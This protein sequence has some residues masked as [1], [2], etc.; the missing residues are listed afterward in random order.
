MK[1][2]DTLDHDILFT[3]LNNFGIGKGILDWCKDYLSSRFQSVKLGGEKSSLFPVTCGVPQG[4]LLGSLYFII[5][6][7]D[8][9]E[10]EMRSG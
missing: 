3:K 4:S 8:L 7:N 5:Y 6:V 1:A 10:E 2:F 9:L